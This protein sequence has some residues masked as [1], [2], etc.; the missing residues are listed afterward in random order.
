[1][2]ACPFGAIAFDE[3]TKTVVMCDLCPNQ[4]QP[5]CIEFCPQKALSLHVS[6]RA[7]S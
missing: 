5:R 4:A 2:E 1:L 3:S 7:E 6:N